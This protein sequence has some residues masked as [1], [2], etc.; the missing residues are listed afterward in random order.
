MEQLQKLKA[1]YQAAVDF[2]AAHP[3]VAVW[4]IAALV[5]LTIVASVL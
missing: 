2:V 3:A 4:A 5:V 1:Y